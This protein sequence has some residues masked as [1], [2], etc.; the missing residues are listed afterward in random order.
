MLSPRTVIE[1]NQRTGEV[2]IEGEFISDNSC[3]QVLD[4]LLSG[5]AKDVDDQD[6]QLKP[7]GFGGDCSQQV[8]LS[9]G[10]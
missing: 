9:Q 7:E 6:T 2:R 10:L 3:Q 1:I 5:L 8:F 4:D